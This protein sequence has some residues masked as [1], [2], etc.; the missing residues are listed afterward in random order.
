MSVAT[1]QPT[2]KPSKK[3]RRAQPPQRTVPAII[4]YALIALVILSAALIRWRLRDMPLERDEGEYAYAGQLMLQGIPP[5]QLAYNM[6]LPG[7]YAAYALIL[8]AFGQTPAAIHIGLLLVNAATTLLMFLLARRLFGNLAGFVAGATYA[9]LSTSESVLGFAGHATHFVVL[10]AVAGILLLL[11]ALDHPALDSKRTFLFFASGLLAGLAFLMKQPGIFFAIFSAI[12]MVVEE[13]QKRISPRTDPKPPFDFPQLA[14]RLASYLLGVALPFALTCLWM[15][16]THVF[17]KFWFWTF[18]YATQYGTAKSFASGVDE[19]WHVLPHIFGHAVFLWVIALVGLTA[20][21]WDAPSRK[22]AAFLG[23]FTLFS[24]LAVCPGLYFRAH[25]FILMLPAVAL[26]AALGVRAAQQNL[27]NRGLLRFAPVL[28][29]LAASTYAVVRDRQFLFELDPIAACRRAYS[30]NPF[31]EAVDIA[32]YLRGHSAPDAT[33]AILGSE[34]EIYF[35]AHRHS[36]TGYIYVYPLMEDQKYAATMQ[37]EMIAEIE[38]AHP[39]FMIV[40]NVPFSWLMKPTSDTALFDWAAQYISSQYQQVGVAEIAHGAT[41]YR[42]DADAA[43][44]HPSS[45]Y[46]VLVFKRK[47]Q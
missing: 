38:A 44:Y 23:G 37:Q 24:F 40:V 25:Y 26:L 29:F 4:Y 11:Y 27:Q 16:R 41:Q 42:W 31:V 20:L 45:P 32:D 22:Y 13:F 19:L 46:N 34:P 18:S 39:E 15:W 17:Q 8:G 1:P 33:A 43:S 30:V 9:L 12:Y 47:P 5:Y 36:A 6:K 28:L 35:Y 14:L 10:P 21:A 2:R 3:S 7:T